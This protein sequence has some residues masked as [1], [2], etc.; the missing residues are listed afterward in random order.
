MLISEDAVRCWWESVQDEV[1]LWNSEHYYITF[2][3]LKYP[4]SADTSEPYSRNRIGDPRVL[5]DIQLPLTTF[6]NYK[7]F[8]AILETEA[9]TLYDE[10]SDGEYNFELGFSSYVRSHAVTKAHLEAFH[11]LM[12]DYS[13]NNLF[14]LTKIKGLKSV[15]FTGNSFHSYR[16]IVVETREELQ[17]ELASTLIEKQPVDTAWV[18]FCI[19][20]GFSVLRFTHNHKQPINRVPI[21]TEDNTQLIYGLMMTLRRTVGHSGAFKWDIVNTAGN[22]AQTRLRPYSFRL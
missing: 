7:H 5:R 10:A 22:D 21:V 15:L 4:V 18:G 8:R 17:E 16:K 2:Q 14:D 11:L 12:A 9:Q 19:K 1:G 20:K 3:L 6:S 13:T